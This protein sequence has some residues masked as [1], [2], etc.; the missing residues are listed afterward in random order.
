MSRVLYLLTGMC[1]FFASPSVYADQV[2][3]HRS[4]KFSLSVGIQQVSFDEGPTKDQE[5]R[6]PS[7]KLTAVSLIGGI[8]VLEYLG[9]EGEVAMGFGKTTQ[10]DGTYLK[11]HKDYLSVAAQGTVS[12]TPGN[13][14]SDL[15][16]IRE[17]TTLGKPS[18]SVKLDHVLGVS[19]RPQ[20]PL[21]QHVR[22][23]AKL[24][25][26]QVS[27]SISVGAVSKDTANIVKDIPAITRSE[28]LTGMIYGLGIEAMIGGMF[29]ARID[30]VNYDKIKGGRSIGL[31]LVV[32]F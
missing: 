12:T 2:S 1:V 30:W 16:D 9:V 25:A 22:I 21:S 11:L 6:L 17:L 7:N 18:V 3:F 20:F 32:R 15:K 23:F 4:E 10:K 27:R 13:A 29:G 8:D 5:L 14:S 19:L 28:T 31:S 24:G 26:A